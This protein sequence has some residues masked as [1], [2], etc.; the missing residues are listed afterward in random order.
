MWFLANLGSIQPV[1]IPPIDRNI[2]S[3]A[4]LVF[5]STYL[6]KFLVAQLLPYWL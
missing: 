5:E 6:I 3:K 4:I 1:H 2:A